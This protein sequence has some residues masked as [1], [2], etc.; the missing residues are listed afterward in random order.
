[1]QGN[2]VPGGKCALPVSGPFPMTVYKVGDGHTHDAG[3]PSSSTTAS[4][5]FAPAG[6]QHRQPQGRFGS[7]F[8]PVAKRSAV[9]AR[10]NRR[11]DAPASGDRMQASDK[12][13]ANRNLLG[14]LYTRTSAS[15]SARAAPHY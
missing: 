6:R 9:K 14:A 15:T 8:G 3:L 1:M 10:S 11:G 12:L 4:M 2:P 5:F 13:R 7:Y